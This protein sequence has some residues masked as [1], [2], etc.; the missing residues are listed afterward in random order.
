M[1]LITV[2]A[3]DWS[4]TIWFERNLGFLSAICTSNIVHFTWC[5]KIP[6]T[7][8]GS[9]S[10]FHYYILPFIFGSLFPRTAGVAYREG[11]FNFID[12]NNHNKRQKLF[13][14]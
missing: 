1:F 10:F 11:V 13:I 2:P 4:V 7:T 8:I 6:T 5:T 9:I 14:T 3:V 12:E